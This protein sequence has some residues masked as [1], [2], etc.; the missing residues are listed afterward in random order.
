MNTHNFAPFRYAEKDIKRMMGELIGA[1]DRSQEDGQAQW[2][3][4]RAAVLRSRAEAEAH[5]K[6]EQVEA[7]AIKSFT[8]RR[9]RTAPLLAEWATERY[10]RE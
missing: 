3:K 5:A 10:A 9:E 2:K 8:E 4:T 1:F 6:A 7:E